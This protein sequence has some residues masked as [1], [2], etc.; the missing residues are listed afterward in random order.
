M[1]VRGESWAPL[2]Q[3]SLHPEFAARGTE[4]LDRDVEYVAESLRQGALLRSGTQ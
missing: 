3:V 2:S 1:F 4:A